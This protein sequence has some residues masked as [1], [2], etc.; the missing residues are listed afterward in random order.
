MALWKRIYFWILE[1]RVWRH[2]LKDYRRAR[3]LYRRSK[4]YKLCKNAFNLEYPDY[5]FK[6]GRWNS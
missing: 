1:R 4:E 6:T 3:R 2:V 5:N